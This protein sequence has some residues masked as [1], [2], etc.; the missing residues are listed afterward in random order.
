[1]P[2]DFIGHLLRE[3]AWLQMWV[4]WMVILNSASIVFLRRREA[5][6]VLSAWIANM[7][8]MSIL[9]AVNGFNRLLGLSHVLWWTPLVIYLWRRLPALERSGAFAAWL[10]ILLVTD[11]LSL[12]VDFSDVI[13][14]LLGDRS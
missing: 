12:V 4:A 5:R 1:M 10:R 3:P 7:I 13:R 8:F 11:T 2:A 6:W 9:F 14:Y